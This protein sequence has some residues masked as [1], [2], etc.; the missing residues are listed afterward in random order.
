MHTEP[1]RYEAPGFE[2]IDLACEISAYAPDGGDIP[3]F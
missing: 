1:R 2:L 3:L